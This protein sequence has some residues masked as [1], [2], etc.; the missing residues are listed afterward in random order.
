M[1]FRVLEGARIVGDVRIGDGSSVWYNAVLRGDLEPIEIGRCSNIQDNCVVHTSRGY[2]VRVGDCVSVGHAAVLHGCI[3]ADNVLIGM[4]STI[5]N[6]AV[7]G[8]NSIVGAGAVVTSGKEFPPG[9]LIIGTPARA[10]RELSDEEIESIRDN[11]RR[12]ALLARE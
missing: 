4:N 9:S 10:V 2:P 6:G 11:A 8:E 3:V 5:L 7:I 1:G 12:Y